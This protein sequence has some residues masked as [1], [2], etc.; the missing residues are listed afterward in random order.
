MFRNNNAPQFIQTPYITTVDKNTVDNSNIFTVSAVDADTRAPYNT[1]TLSVIGD[2]NAPSLFS[3]TQ[4]GNNGVI[5]VVSSQN[6]ASDTANSYKLRVLVADG[7]FPSLTAT[8]TV[9]ITVRRN[10]FAPQFQN[11][12]IRV[13]ISEST[14][15]GSNITRVFATD[16]DVDSP[17]NVFRYELIGDG[18]GP[19]YFFVNQNDG[20]V[21]LIRSVL[22]TGASGYVLKIRA[23]DQGFPQLS[24]IATVEVVITRVTEVLSFILPSYTRII[25][26]NT[27]VAINQV[28]QVSAQPGPDVFYDLTG[29]SD[30]PDYF[31]ISS[32]TGGIFVRKDLRLDHQ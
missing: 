4:S 6:L 11:T 22:N 13:T 2:D 12:F 29:F 19:S 14:V 3:L 10:L 7:G 25:S 5:R 31:N 9:D 17:N 21:T 20:S 23:I 26:E 28:T 30:G 16:Q 27:A 8:A 1:L 24:S 18:D 32:V 15:V